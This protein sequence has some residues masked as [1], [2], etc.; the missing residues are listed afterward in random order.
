M[1]GLVRATRRDDAALLLPQKREALA[2]A[3]AQTSDNRRTTYGNQHGSYAQGIPWG[4]GWEWVSPEGSQ[5]V[6]RRA[7]GDNPCVNKGANIVIVEACS[8]F[9]FAGLVLPFFLR[10]LLPF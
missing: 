4:L 10:L 5:A 1:G 8:P 9:C 7:S 6:H 2:E 3:F